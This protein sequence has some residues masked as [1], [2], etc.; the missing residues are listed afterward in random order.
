M[1]EQAQEGSSLLLI[2]AKVISFLMKNSINS[3]ANYAGALLQY[4]I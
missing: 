4:I 1:I 2:V 3:L